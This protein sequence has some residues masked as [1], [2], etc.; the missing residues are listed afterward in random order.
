MFMFLQTPVLAV[1]IPMVLFAVIYLVERRSW[2]LRNALAVLAP[3]ISFLLLLGSYPQ[4]IAGERVFIEFPAILPPLGMSF[5]IDYLSLLVGLVV[6]FVWLLVTIYATEYMVKEHAKNRYYP[7]STLTLAGTMGVIL[8]GDLFTFFLFFELMSLSA[9]VL[10]VHEETPEAMRAGYKYLVL[11]IAGGLALFFATIAVFEIAGTVSFAPGGFIA[12]VSGLAIMAFYAFLIGFG[13]KAGIV[14]LHVWLPEAHPVAPSPAS[15]LLSGVMLKTGAYGMIRVVF[16]VFGYEG[17]R[18]AG[19]DNSM[20]VLAAI[21]IFLG[22]AVAISQED[23]KR[24]LAYSSVGQM[25]YIL[26]GIGL[27]QERALIGAIF[28]IFAHAVMKSSLFLAAGAVIHKTGKRRI[29]EWNGLGQEMT[30]TMLVFTV[31]A[32][33]MVG[34]PPLVGFVSKWELALGSLDAGNWG[35]VLLL[36]LSSMMNFIYYFPLIQ[37]TLFGKQQAAEGQA[38]NSPELPWKMLAP[39]VVLA[40]IIVLIDLFPQNP[41]LDLAKRAAGALFLGVH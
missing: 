20:L 23:I 9:Y 25:G 14:P 28:H 10:I 7:F 22:S 3:L 13:I 29:S 11:T 2:R 39:M 31:A 6:S 8:S 24:R 5:S 40:L 1:I 12:E 15:A 30:V 16:N 34:I 26:L 19:L 32:L 37:N 41:A 21:T 33:S 36:L 4:V 35:F 27:L 18:G 17:I 38:S